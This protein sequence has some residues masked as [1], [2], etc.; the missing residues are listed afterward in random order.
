M[1]TLLIALTIFGT[2]IVALSWFALISFLYDMVADKFGERIGVYFLTIGVF[3][4]PVTAALTA[5]FHFN[6]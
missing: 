4:I 1:G 2:I 3:A 6:Q 5:I